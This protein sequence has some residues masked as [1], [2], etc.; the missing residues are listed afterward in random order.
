MKFNRN[1]RKKREIKEKGDDRKYNKGK[2]KGYE[3]WRKYR[4]RDN[5]NRKEV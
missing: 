3:D 4:K 2:G 5:E 1:K